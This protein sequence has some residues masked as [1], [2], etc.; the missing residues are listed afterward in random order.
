MR[1][2]KQNKALTQEI[3]AYKN[4]MKKLKEKMRKSK[5]TIDKLRNTNESLYKYIEK[6]L[7]DSTIQKH[8]IDIG[9]LHAEEYEE[10]IILETKSIEQV[11]E[12]D[13][14]ENLV[15]YTKA[16][17]DIMEILSDL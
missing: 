12:E 10:G 16:E 13:I 3:E 11:I 7:Y 15:V 6:N 9:L 2:Q 8:F 4:D 1:Y 14:K 17:A 5:D